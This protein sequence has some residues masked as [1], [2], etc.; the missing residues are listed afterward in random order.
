MDG[1]DLIHSTKEPSERPGPLR[2]MAREF[3]EIFVGDLNAEMK[4]ILNVID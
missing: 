3:E 2:S 1:E 4:D